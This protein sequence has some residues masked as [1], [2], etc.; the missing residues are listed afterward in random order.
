MS[1]KMTLQQISEELGVSVQTVSN[2]YRGHGRVGLK[3]RERVQA[4]LT[5]YNYVPSRAAQALRGQPTGLLG[6]VVQDPVYTLQVSPYLSH[7]LVSVS[8]AIRDAGFKPLVT[9]LQEEHPAQ[10]LSGM[11]GMVDG[12]LLLSKLANEGDNKKLARLG[13]PIVCF[14][15][16]NDTLPFVTA[17]Y[18]QATESLVRR[19]C[20]QGV[21]HFAYVGG[22]DPRQETGSARERLEGFL[23]GVR[24]CGLPAPA[25][26]GGNWSLR[27]G[28]DA[29]GKLWD[30]P[31]RPEAIIC[32][33]DQ[34][35]LGVLQA[36]LHAGVR[37]PD[38]LQITGFDD[39]GHLDDSSGLLPGFPA[40]SSV[41]LPLNDMARQGVELLL[42]CVRDPEHPPESVS[43]PTS[44]SARRTTRPLPPESPTDT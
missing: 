15:T 30:G 32:G 3:T 37:V 17:Q 43:M 21:R 8:G 16:R 19:L 36:A 13:M 29:F 14:D 11:S 25:L 39:L 22:T 26:V 2:V 6:F 24:G 12:L 28:W 5:R 31:Q 4:A 42:R 20:A 23:R 9:L 18:G 44:F 33:N 27:D 35:A 40:L 10:L 1:S 41:K 7:A 38:E 34:M